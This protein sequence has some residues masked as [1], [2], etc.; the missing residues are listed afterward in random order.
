MNTASDQV[1]PIT[2]DDAPALSLVAPQ[3]LPARAPARPHAMVV[4]LAIAA[5][6]LS[7][8]LAASL[9]IWLGTSPSP[10]PP[11][12]TVVSGQGAP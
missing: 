1:S 11:V 10:A 4:A 5:G 7:A 3:A 2:A 6:I 8:A 9:T 12:P